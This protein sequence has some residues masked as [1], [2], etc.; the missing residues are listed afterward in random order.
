M[1]TKAMF[2]MV[3]STVFINASF[4]GQLAAQ[5]FASVTPKTDEQA[6]QLALLQMRDVHG[7]LCHRFKCPPFTLFKNSSVRNA[8]TRTS[9]AGYSIR[10]NEDF[11]SATRQSFGS[12][13]ILGVL[14]HELG[15]IIDTNQ[16]RQK[17]SLARREANADVYAGCVFALARH[18]ESDLKGFSGSLYSMGSSPGY[19]T[20]AQRVLL[21]QSGYYQCKDKEMSARAFSRDQWRM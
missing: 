19:P 18:P 15:H 12:L 7:L 9:K 8:M 1:N 11:M 17:L 3:T 2:L 6:S 5:T 13:A 14:A 4:S 10:Y 21:V 20:P 16:N